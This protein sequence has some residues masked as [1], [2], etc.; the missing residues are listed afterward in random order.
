MCVRAH[1]HVCARANVRARVRGRVRE[2][3]V[4][5]CEYVRVWLPI[6]PPK[7]KL[8]RTH[9][10]PPT[11]TRTHTHSLTHIHTH[12]R[13]RSDRQTGPRAYVTLL[14]D[15]SRQQLSNELIITDV[16]RCLGR[17][18]TTKRGLLAAPPQ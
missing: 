5:M 6:L 17:L 15:S 16:G 1:V 14:M 3:H 7:L 8:K 4:F 2:S 10:N 11:H 9:T 18:V 13:A 12:T